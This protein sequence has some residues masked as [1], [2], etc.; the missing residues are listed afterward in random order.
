MGTGEPER[1]IAAAGQIKQ[2]RLGE[3]PSHGGLLPAC[4]LGVNLADSAPVATEEV[5]LSSTIGLVT[6]RR[7]GIPNTFCAVT[8][9]MVTTWD[10]SNPP[11][12][13][14]T[15]GFDVIVP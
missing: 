8:D 14:N 4:K 9:Q 1:W 6:V 12:V 3:F 2:L 11:N 10:V 15:V 13:V 7:S 5:N